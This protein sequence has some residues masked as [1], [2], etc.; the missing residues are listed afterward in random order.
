MH[1]MKKVYRRKGMTILFFE[2][3]ASGQ[4]RRV[5]QH[6]GWPPP[7]ECEGEILPPLATFYNFYM[8][9]RDSRY[10]TRRFFHAHRDGEYKYGNHNTH[11][12]ICSRR[13]IAPPS[14]RFQDMQQTHQ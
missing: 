1:T 11:Y 10:N 14:A 4:H 7:H 12:R 3:Q 2:N 8:D 5:L 13:K 9:N 6:P